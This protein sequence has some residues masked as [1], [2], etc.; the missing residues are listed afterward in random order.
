MKDDDV[1][2]WPGITLGFMFGR[3]GSDSRLLGTDLAG[4]ATDSLTE[5]L[6]MV[7]KAFN[8]S[9]KLLSGSIRRT[10]VC[11]LPDFESS[12][13]ASFCFILSEISEET[14]RAG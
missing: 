13:F 8:L 10:G 6:S 7:L 12:K 9:L 11:S 3:F 14:L 1:D 5:E 2:L 4:A